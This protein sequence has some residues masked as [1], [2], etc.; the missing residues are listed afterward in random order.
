MIALISS[1]V[2]VRAIPAIAVGAVALA[3]ATWVWTSRA[4]AIDDLRVARERLD[5]MEATLEAERIR[6]QDAQRIADERRE[7][8]GRVEVAT[9][10]C[11]DE[12]LPPDLWD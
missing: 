8:D 1:L 9:D 11:L 4:A 12:P 5:T 7:R 2:S 6:L 3:A 10:A